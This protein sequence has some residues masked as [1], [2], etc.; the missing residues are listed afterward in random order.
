[1]KSEQAGN[2]AVGKGVWYHDRVATGPKAPA[3]LA[4]SV[5]RKAAWKWH[6]RNHR[7]GT[8]GRAT[9]SR[10]GPTRGCADSTQ[11]CQFSIRDVIG[12]PFCPKSLAGEAAPQ[13]RRSAAPRPH[14]PTVRCRI[15][16]LPPSH[17]T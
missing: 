1:M 14:P 3:E 6:C 13:P 5:R 4:P 15:G 2:K 7:I 12:Y 9:A 16:P 8:L 11:R 17:G 10:V